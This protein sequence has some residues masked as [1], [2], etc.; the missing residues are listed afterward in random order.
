MD[1]DGEC[2]LGTGTFLAQTVGY[3]LNSAIWCGVADRQLSAHCAARLN[4]KNGAVD[5]TDRR[6]TLNLRG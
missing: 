4:G 3:P 6:N 1:A 5:S 2:L